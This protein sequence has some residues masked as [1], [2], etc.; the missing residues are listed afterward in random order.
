VF[1]KEFSMKRDMRYI[2]AGVHE[3]GHSLNSQESR[4]PRLRAGAT[5]LGDTIGT[6][7]GLVGGLAARSRF[8]AVGGAAVGSG[9]TALG[10]LPV[11]IEEYQASKRALKALKESGRYSP[12]EYK[13]A[14]KL[15]DTA[16]KTYVSSAVRRT[17]LVGGITSGNVA[18]GVGMI[19]AGAVP[20]HLV[21]KEVEKR[22]AGKI[23]VKGD[24]EEIRRIQRQMGSRAERV[25]PS[26]VKHRSPVYVRPH[27]DVAW[28][29]S[30]KSY[31]DSIEEQLGVRPTAKQ[32]ER[33]M[34]HIG[35]PGTTWLKD[36]K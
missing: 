27:K 20:D 12:A 5:S 22:F 2:A 19:G 1:P 11:L 13:E 15:L 25:N 7:G 26:K 34:V 31:Q 18:L 17:A 16:Y 21:G 14:K 10:H 8:G 6:A 28:L 23:G 4:Y 29:T 32:L 35:R 9:I 3:H 30:K 24:E 33:G 36:K